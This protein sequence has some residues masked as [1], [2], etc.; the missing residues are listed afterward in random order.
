MIE[1]PI[2]QVC[3]LRGIID[4]WKQIVYYDFDG[5]MSKQFLL[6]RYSYQN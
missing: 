5:N 4:S 1:K 6:A 2:V 3:M